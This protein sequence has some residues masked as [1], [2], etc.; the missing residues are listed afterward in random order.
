MKVNDIGPT[1]AKIM[2]VGEAPGKEEERLGEP[3]VG[4]SGKMLRQLLNHS[5]IDYYRCY[6]TNV[7]DERPP[8]NNFNFFYADKRRNTPT[9]SLEKY[10]QELRAKIE[11]IK[12]NVVIPLGG[13]ALRAITGKRKISEWRGTPMSYKGIK[14]IPTYHPRY[15]ISQYASH[16]IVELDLAKAREESED[17][18]YDPNPLNI[19]IQPTLS[20]ATD[21]LAEASKCD[22]VAFDIET[23]GKHVRCISLAREGVG[24]PTAISIPFFQFPSSSL[25][26]VSPG[27]R[28]VNFS[29]TAEGKS[30]YWSKH[31]EIEVLTE[32]AELFANDKIQKVGQ[33]SISFDAPLIEDEFGITINNHYADTMHMWH[34]LY[35]EFPKSLSF[36]CSVLTNYPNYWT[37]KDSSDDRS[38]WHYNCMDAVV[39]LEVS[40]LIEKELK[41]SGLD[42]LYSDHVHPLAFALSD[43]SRR[44]VLVDKAARDELV[45]SAKKTIETVQ[46]EINDLAGRELNPNSSQQVQKLLYEELMFPTIYKDGVSTAN[47]EALRKLEKRYPNEKL[48]AKI[49][50]YRKSSKLMSTFLDVNVDEDGRMRTSYNASGTKTGRISSSQNLWGGGMN[51]QNIPVGKSR[52]IT[53]IRHMFIAG[54]NNVFVKGDLRQAETMVVAHILF[55]LGDAVLYNLYSKGDFDIHRWMAS[56]I[57][58]KSESEVNSYEREVGKLANHSGNYCAGPRVLQAKALKDGIEGIDYPVAQRILEARHEAIP[59]LKG[60]WADVERKLRQTRTL[61]TCLGRRRIFFGRLDDNATIRDAVSYEPQSTVGDVCN[62]IFTRLHETFCGDS[63]GGHTKEKTGMGSSR[64]SLSSSLEIWPIL[65]V[66]DE[67]IVECPEGRSDDVARAMQRAAIVPLQ[68]NDEPLIIPIDVSVGRNWRDCK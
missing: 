26:S 4:Q 67:V 42:K 16:P 49:I 31:D 60:W 13:E 3:F 25:A 24:M 61:T 15:I 30:S 44:G 64:R 17:S 33:N 53:N 39:T 47:E 28:F 62:I 14:V 68:I 66:H 32:I 48:L 38:M 36:L 63:F 35:P 57:F 51:L 56:F 8:G 22:R 58:D 19:I 9:T 46:K 7:V 20:Q 18:L 55:R 12:P 52:G 37:E 27:D 21:W 41:S 23:V 65:Q 54:E 50:E 2:L 11:R 6:T 34:V 29:G 59:G 43:A 45:V 5:K 1:D 40:Y 10:W